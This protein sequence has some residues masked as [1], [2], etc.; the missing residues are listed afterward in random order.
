MSKPTPQ[1]KVSR[2]FKLG[3]D[4]TTLDFVDVPIGHDLPVFLDPSRL[5]T[6]T[7][8]WAS[9]CNSLL[10]HFFE[11]LLAHLRNNEEAAG[12]SMLAHLTEKN[13]FHFGLSKGLSDGRAFGDGYAHK[14]WEAI[15][16]SK[17]GVSGL[18]VDLEDTCLF[19]EGIGP[20]RISDA[21]CN[22]VRGPLIRYTQDMCTYYGIPLV[23]NVDSGPIWN[24]LTET[25]ENALVSLPLTPY[26]KLLLVPKL[27]VRQQLVY[28]YASYF[29]HHLLPAMQASEKKL[30]T[31]LVH[32]L[33]DGRKR[34]TKKSLLEKYGATKLTVVEQ[35]LRH[36]DALAEYRQ[37]AQKMSRPIS[38][39]R[40]ADI[41]NI[42][43]PNFEA[44]LAAVASVLPGREA[45]G[46]YEDAIEKLLS[47]LFFP[48]LS[49][50]VKQH[51][52]HDGRK[53]VD[54]TYVNNPAEGFFKWLL[55]HYPSSHIFVECKNYG[56]EVGNP[57]I[58]QLAGRF[59]PSRG[60]VGILVCRTVEK[61]Q[62]LKDSCKD[63]ANDK[64]GYIITL[65]D[66]ELGELV[67]DYA[68]TDGGAGFP[69]LMKK[70]RDLIM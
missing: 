31:G 32:T 4:Q 18:L 68:S 64:R 70:F 42:P 57:E 69:L 56:K 17:A 61:A 1:T 58:D 50:P 30:N 46:E 39:Q 24:P 49:S 34:V 22:I 37:S 21:V 44:L 12:I 54:I 51:K 38:H 11:T 40:L 3:R 5:R 14:I 45:A 36:P 13:E 19:I 35:T 28:D 9:E 33:K 48:S 63:T 26:G 29:T 27:A 67:K 6:M 23:E 8:D 55:S 25:W 62:K 43:R 65:T 53:R 59:S 41:E 10:Q 2:Y 20:D 66:D 52:I 60:Q 15:K 16:N 47:A 7:S